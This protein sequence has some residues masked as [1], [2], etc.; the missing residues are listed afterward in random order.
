M[1]FE[2]PVLTTDRADLAFAVKELARTMSKPTS[3][4]WEKLK[5]LGRYLV[6]KPR[7]ILRFIWQEMP[8]KINIYTDADWAGCKRTS[9]STSG[10]SIMLGRHTLKTWSSTQATMLACAIVQCHRE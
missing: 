7:A 8:R 1:S 6:G 10:G 2:D 9:R 3:V 5:R 4:C